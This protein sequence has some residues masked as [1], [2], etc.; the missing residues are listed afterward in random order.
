[1]GLE[2]VL[3]LLYLLDLLVDDAY[4]YNCS[5]EISSLLI[6]ISGRM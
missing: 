4:H 1:M 6:R 3:I 5:T 2:E